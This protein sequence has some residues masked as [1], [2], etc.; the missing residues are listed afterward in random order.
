[1]TPVALP[2]GRRTG[3]ELAVKRSKTG[4]KQGLVLDFPQKLF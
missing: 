1:M 3:R 4:Q 2:A